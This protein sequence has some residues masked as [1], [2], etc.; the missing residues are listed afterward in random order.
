MDGILS[1]I[2]HTELRVVSVLSVSLYS[3]MF[4]YLVLLLCMLFQYY[5]CF[6]G[7]TG[8]INYN[9]LCA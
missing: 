5:Y 2:Y 9:V 3:F 7:G 1:I 6:S 4:F 8:G